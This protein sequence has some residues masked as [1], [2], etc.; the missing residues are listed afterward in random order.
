MQARLNNFSLV[1]VEGQEVVFST[2]VSFAEVYNENVYDLLEPIGTKKQKRQNLAL[3]ED[4]KG[5]V[6]IKG[7]RNFKLIYDGF[8]VY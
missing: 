3:G 8:E 4:N 7:K 5:Q 6:Y 1:N 2:W